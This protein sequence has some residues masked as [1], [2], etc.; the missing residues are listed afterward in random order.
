MSDLL[1]RRKFLITCAAASLLAG[2]DGV[3]PVSGF[4]AGMKVWNGKFE[5]LLFSP[6]HGTVDAH[7]DNLPVENYALETKSTHMIGL[8]RSG[9][10]SDRYRR[11]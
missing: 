7:I 4:L 2:C 1:T 3:H 8:K 9:F 5:E 6:R 11:L 10:L